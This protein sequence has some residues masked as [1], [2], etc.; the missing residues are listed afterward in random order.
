[1]PDI[2][3][4]V[5]RKYGLAAI[6]FAVVFAFLVWALAHFA[7][8][9]GTEVT[10]LWGLAK[11]TKPDRTK[12]INPV[13]TDSH[14]SFKA[15]NPAVI[16]PDSLHY[17]PPGDIS[18]ISQISA[19]EFDKMLASLRA[20]NGL[21]Q[22]TTLESGKTVA[23]LPTDSYFFLST[24]YLRTYSPQTFESRVMT[25]V[26]NRYR[27]G[28]T[29]FEIHSTRSNGLSLVGVTTESDA[30]RISKLS[31]KPPQDIVLSPLPWGSMTTLVVLPVSRVQSC[32]DRDLQT[33]QNEEHRILDIKVK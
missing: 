26:S 16:L 23:E 9:P 15:Q 5:F 25:A 14:S 22:L 7:S 10:V 1:M 8:A 31:G 3:S 30:A 6:L 12:E 32:N 29:Y 19:S 28:S 11:Y 24:V 17:S 33:S 21:R 18:T 2:A 4:E 13:S 27:A 20:K